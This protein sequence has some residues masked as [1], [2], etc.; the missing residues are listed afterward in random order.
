MHSRF[1]TKLATF[2]AAFG[3]TVLGLTASAEAASAQT[4]A[5]LVDVNGVLRLLDFYSLNPLF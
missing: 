1:T 2:S 4:V 5:G 3:I